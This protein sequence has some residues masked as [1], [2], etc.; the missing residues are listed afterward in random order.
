MLAKT[1]A[2]MRTAKQFLT[3]DEAASLLAVRKETLYSWVCTRRVPHYRISGRLVRFDP[4]EL[5]AWVEAR[6]VHP[7]STRA[8]R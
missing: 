1:E 5:V 4:D 8:G 2:G 3:Y 7:I 6:R